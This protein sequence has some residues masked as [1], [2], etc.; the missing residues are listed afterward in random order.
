AELLELIGSGVEELYAAGQEIVRQGDRS[1]GIFVL[2]SGRVRV[3]ETVDGNELVLGE[4]GAGEIFGELGA[5]QN[6]PRS[7]T[8]IAADETRC[9]KLLHSE[10]LTALKNSPQLCLALQRMIA[11]RLGHTDLLVARHAPDPVTGL[12][13]RLAFGE[14]YRRFASSARRRKS[15]LLLLAIDIVQLKRINDRY[16][17]QTGDDVLRAVADTLAEVG[18]DHGLVSRY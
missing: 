7:A 18:G 9:L 11:G 13:G 15:S 17:Y 12:P 16:G 5:L 4:F 10:F 8:V 3:V 6:R 14:L 1:D 2:L